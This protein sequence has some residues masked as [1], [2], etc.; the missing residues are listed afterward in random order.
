M[1]YDEFR[2]KKFKD[3]IGQGLNGDILKNQI[4]NSNIA[5]SYLFEG[6][7]GSGKTTTARIFAKAINCLNPIDG[8]PCCKCE[9]CKAIEAGV[10]I[11]VKEIDA[12]SNNGVDNIREIIKNMNY[13][14]QLKYKVYILDEAHMLST[15]AAN[16]FLKMLEEP[17]EFAVFILCTTEANKLPVTI[18]SRCQKYT[19]SRIKANDIFDRLD[20]V[21]KQKNYV[22]DTNALKLIAKLS[23]GAMRD[24]LSILEQI[25]SSGMSDYNDIV[26]LLGNSTNK[27][28]FEVIDALIAKNSVKAIELFHDVLE[29]GRNIQYFLEGI[30]QVVRNIML[31]KAGVNKN[32]I[33]ATDEEIFE[34]QEMSQKLDIKRNISILEILK[35]ALED[36]KKTSFADIVVEMSIIKITK[37]LGDNAEDKV[38]FIDDE[39]K[40]LGIEA[41]SEEGPFT[42]ED[43]N[44]IN[45][46][47]D[48]DIIDD[49]VIYMIHYLYEKGDD[50]IADILSRAAIVKV[51]GKNII[52]I[53]TEFER[54]MKILTSFEEEFNF[55][56]IG[57]S[58]KIGKKFTVE[59]S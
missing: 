33:A 37:L 7:R 11:D 5:H 30:I 48:N 51:K 41:V 32:S 15:S 45:D 29:E 21:A 8:E 59:I 28:I 24:A 52:N 16:A 23:D 55:F 49:V 58:K 6:N 47:A 18:L 43:N 9:A 26:K 56:E 44:E 53:F 4:A 38:N 12:A 2:P 13:K 1:L 35:N 34:M 40:S 54:D 22:I 46:K 25:I 50:K 14:P 27:K 10:A 3:V 42:E 57:F 17:P 39:I 36:I 19:Y 31:I 20:F